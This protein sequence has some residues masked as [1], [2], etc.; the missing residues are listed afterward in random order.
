MYMDIVGVEVG[1][2]QGSLANKRRTILASLR[3]RYH[4]HQTILTIYI[5]DNYTVG[6][7]MQ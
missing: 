1:V 5:E 7:P 6:T 4:G 3:A 2:S